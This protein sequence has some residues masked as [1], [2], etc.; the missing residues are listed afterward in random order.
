MHA[1]FLYHAI[2]AGMDM[3]IVNAGQLAAL[4]EIDAELLE[5]I[6]DVLFDR[7]EDATDRLIDF[8]ETIKGDGESGSKKVDE[9]R[10]LDVEGRLAHALL[11]G[12]TDHV[13]EDIEEART[14]YETG[15]QIIEGPLMSGMQIVGDLFGEGKMFLPQVVKSACHEEGCRISC[16]TWKRKRRLKV[17][18]NLNVVVFSSQ[19]SKVTFMTLGRILLVSF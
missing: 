9:W 19:P 10:E 7:R 1:A 14:K 13:E 3:G 5:K 6:E 4:E 16:L 12:L 18:P 2:K 11:K 15:L 17:S 8:A